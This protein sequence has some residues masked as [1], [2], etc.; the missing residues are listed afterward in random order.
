M[1]SLQCP[2]CVCGRGCEG[3][4]Q[5]GAPV[6][7][8]QKEFHVLSGLQEGTP[9]FEQLSKQPGQ[10]GVTVIIPSYSPAFPPSLAGKRAHKIQL[11]SSGLK[12]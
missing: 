5:L 1:V 12:S 2:G 4:S 9:G 3:L 6:L 7:L 10:A 11:D 8:L